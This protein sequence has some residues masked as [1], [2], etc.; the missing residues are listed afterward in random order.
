VRTWV[1]G[2]VWAI[3][4]LLVFLGSPLSGVADVVSSSGDDPTGKRAPWGI[5]TLRSLDRARVLVRGV[6]NDLLWPPLVA[7]LQRL[8]RIAEIPGLDPDGPMVLLVRFQ[9]TSF[10]QPQLTL[11]LPVTDGPRFMQVCTALP[12]LTVEEI[13]Q[14]RW[15]IKGG[16]HELTIVQSDGR[17]LVT[18]HAPLLDHPEVIHDWLRNL[19]VTMDFSIRIQPHG[20]PEEIQIQWRESIVRELSRLRTRVAK[21]SEKDA[22][23]A[24]AAID[25]LEN[26]LKRWENGTRQLDIGVRFDDALHGELNWTALPGSALGKDLASFQLDAARFE[27]TEQETEAFPAAEMT[28]AVDVPP[29]MRVLAEL[30]FDRVRE[31]MIRE[32]GPRIKKEDQRLAGGVFDAIAATIATG[33]FESHL[34]FVPVTEGRMVLYG[35]ISGQQSDRL[36]ESLA[37]VLPYASQTKEVR[38]VE[39]NAVQQGSLVAHRIVPT[40]VRSDDRL[41][42]GE[43]S[44]LYMG[45]NSYAFLFAVG[46]ADS[47]KVLSQ[48]EPVSEETPALMS[49]RVHLRPWLVLLEQE[50]A[51]ER[52]LWQQLLSVLP[53][54]EPNDL[55][56]FRVATK[57]DQLQMNLTV[58]KGL[59]QMAGS[60]FSGTTKP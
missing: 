15:R 36:G 14:H 52:E 28:F 56:E 21:S 5:V 34:A 7:S 16:N 44:A 11:A 33:R 6:S 17:L 29:P 10:E 12:Y 59:L 37:T 4:L 39:M 35:S 43:D 38:S 20:I 25:F 13:Q 3:W 55:M 53:E 47:P 46:G 60:F 32:I 42:Y 30:A 58:E 18:N 41:L 2:R 54:S 48:L 31:H 50:K 26:G 57:P 45:T 49:L 24:Q 1:A 51:Q 22:F 8:D 40:H 27:R 19:N 9:G 23:L